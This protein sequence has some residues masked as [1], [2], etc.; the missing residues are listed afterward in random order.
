MTRKPY[1]YEAP[2][3]A[4]A[5]PLRHGDRLADSSIYCARRDCFL[6]DGTFVASASATDHV[7]YLRMRFARLARN[8]KRQPSQRSNY[9]CELLFKGG[10]P[11]DLHDF[12]K[13]V[14]RM[15]VAL[16]ERGAP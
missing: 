11:R 13:Q 10:L 15:L 3:R 6:S 2:P 12:D 9:L 16:H 14:P 4:P 5:M 8:R 1:K 7:A